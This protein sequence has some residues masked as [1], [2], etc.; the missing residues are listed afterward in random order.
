MPRPTE[1]T[2]KTLRE[3]LAVRLGYGGMTTAAINKKLLN[4]FL[5]NAQ[6]ELWERLTMNQVRDEVYQWIAP[7]RTYVNYPSTIDPDRIREITVDYSGNDDWEPL[8]EGVE[9]YDDNTIDLLSWPRKYEHQ[10]DTLEVWPRCDARD[11]YI[12][13]GVTL[14]NPIEIDFAAAPNVSADALV[15][16]NDIG[17]TTE[18][19]GNVYAVKA[20][21]GTTVTLKDETTGADIDGTTGFSAFSAGSAANEMRVGYRLKFEGFL[22]LAAFAADSD[23]AT[24]PSNLVFLQALAD[25]KLH[26]NHKDAPEWRNRAKQQLTK[27]RGRIH[28]N[29]RYVPAGKGRFQ[30]TE[31]IKPGRVD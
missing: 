3:D 19:N 31:M 20:L 8:H 17:G 29:R 30:R 15:K 25:A 14:N 16:L 9:W 12:V 18:L 23:T 13:T 5:V 28:G 4:S 1:K 26:Y 6:E 27:Y 7:D 10:N 11:T 22:R 21:A 2:L 24:L